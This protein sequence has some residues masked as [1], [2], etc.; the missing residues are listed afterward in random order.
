V[1]EE[2]EVAGLDIPEHGMY[3]YPE[4]FIP[5]SELEG[6]GATPAARPSDPA[7]AY[8]TRGQEVPAT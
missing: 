1:S 2:D 5:A 3:G 6:Y 7:G 4:Q 8:S